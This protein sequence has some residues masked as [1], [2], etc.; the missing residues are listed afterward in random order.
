[1]NINIFKKVNSL[2]TFI[3]FFIFLKFYKCM[4]VIPIENLDK[5]NYILE[6]GNS[7][8]NIIKNYYFKDL[9]TILEIGTPIQK[10]FLFIRTNHQD[11]EIISKTSYNNKNIGELVNNKYNLYNIFQ[12]YNLFNEKKSLSYISVGC[13]EVLGILDF[14]TICNSNDSFIFYNNINMTKK[15]RYDNFFFK[16]IIDSDND[17]PGEIGLGLFDKYREPEYNFLKLLKNNNL[18]NNYNWYF[19]FDSYLNKNGKLIIGS[20][21]HEDYPKLF[22]E[23]DLFYINV[24]IN[25]FT[26]KNWRLEFDKIYF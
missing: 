11:Y 23:I 19:Q 6:Q 15:I 8:S 21:P 20:L 14:E 2:S 5:V 10:V 13:K 16:L 9:Y 1:M 25:S 7:H 22:S 26:L 12:N 24:D 18:I 4:I 3:I 17:I